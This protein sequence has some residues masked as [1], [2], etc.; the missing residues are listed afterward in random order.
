M[1]VD[2]IAV[3]A[4]N[5]LA[6]LAA[7]I[8][9]EHGASELALKR[10]LD[11]AIACGRLLMEAKTL[12]PH[13][14]WL[15]W[16]REHCGIPERSVQRYMELGAY[17]ADTKSANLADLAVAGAANAVDGEMLAHQTGINRDFDLIAETLSGAFIAQ[18]FVDDSFD[19]IRTKLLRQLRVPAIASWCFQMARMT[20]NGRPALRLCP[21][22]ELAEAAEALAP[23]AKR[24]PPGKKATD[25]N[26]PIKFDATSFESM[27]A[28]R[29]AINQVEVLAAWMLGRVFREMESR[30]HISDEQYANEWDETHQHVMARLDE[31]LGALEHERAPERVS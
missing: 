13:G 29:R 15:P 20:A 30:E 25:L 4:S 31:K 8:K 9:T 12:V 5:W 26:I 18:D 19:W 14:H 16:L 27:G 24:F 10:G 6:D 7:R 21:W 22:N 23:I 2:I 17:A 11:H 3:E 28:M 1:T